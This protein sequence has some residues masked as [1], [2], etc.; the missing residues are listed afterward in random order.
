TAKINH[1][2][3]S[4]KCL[5]VVADATVSIASDKA[6]KNQISALLSSIQNKA[7]ADQ[8]LTEME[9]GFI[10]STTIPVFKYL[11]DPQMLGVSNTLI[12]QLTD[13]IG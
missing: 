5:K 1:C 12:Y 9:K 11:V 13:Y 4:E 10:S 3:D 8:P 7:V 2:N 6:L